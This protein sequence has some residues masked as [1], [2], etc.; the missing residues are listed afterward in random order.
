MFEP[1]LM[2]LSLI[3]FVLLFNY[4]QYKKY[5]K[6]KQIIESVL[7]P[8]CLLHLKEVKCDTY[9]TGAKNS[10][11]QFKTCELFIIQDAIIL[12]GYYKIFNLEINNIPI[13]LSGNVDNFKK[14]F[15][16]A[17]VIK[18]KKINPYS[19]DNEVFI[20]FGE[21]SFTETNIIVRLKNIADDDKIILKN[22]ASNIC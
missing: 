5:A 8:D 7:R 10:G 21:G 1:S 4:L 17:F 12:L 2:I 3:I 19:Y 22:I 20:E 18:P 9:A 6:Q 15:E 11:M 14:K 13:I 16:N